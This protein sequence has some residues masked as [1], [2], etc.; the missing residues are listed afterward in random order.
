MHRVDQSSSLSLSN[1]PPSPMYKTLSTLFHSVYY[2]VQ[3]GI[4]DGPCF[5]VLT[6]MFVDWERAYEHK[7][8][9]NNRSDA[10]L[11]LYGD[12]IFRSGGVGKKTTEITGEELH[13]P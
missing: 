4:T 12:K 11:D 7:K 10:R 1:F 5:L 6:S 3:R 8:K 2:Y 9:K 13:C